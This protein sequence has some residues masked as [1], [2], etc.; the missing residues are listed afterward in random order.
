MRIYRIWVRN[1][2]NRLEPREGFR[3]YSK[4]CEWAE[5]AHYKNYEIE[6]EY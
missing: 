4:A 1:T 3:T 5:K 6:I 2:C